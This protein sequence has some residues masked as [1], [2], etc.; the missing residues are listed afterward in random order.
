[1]ESLLAQGAESV[2]LKQRVYI[3]T[4]FGS[5]VVVK[6][7]FSKKYRHP[8][9]DASLTHR[10]F[11][12]EARNL[13]RARKLGVAV[14]AV[15]YLDEQNKRMYMEMVSPAITVKEFLARM[16]QLSETLLND[17]ASKIARS[18]AKVHEIKCIHGDLTSSN[19]LIK[20]TLATDGSAEAVIKAVS[21]AESVGKLVR[22]IQYLIDFGLSFVSGL[23]EDKAVDLYCL[24]RALLSTHPDS[25]VLVRP[26]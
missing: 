23:P 13:V 9:L 10:R 1:M 7:R 6:E 8:K 2:R 15:L 25:D 24:E 22:P 21:A 20:P 3:S 14:P 26:R 4:L 19:L 17:L 5:Q 16:P 12:Q 11:V 18:I